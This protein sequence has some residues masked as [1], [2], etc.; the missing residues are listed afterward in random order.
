ME[1]EDFQ[2]GGFNDT[3]GT[4]GG[5][6]TGVLGALNKPKPARAATPAPNRQNEMLLKYGLIAGGVLLVIV[7]VLSL[8]RR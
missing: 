5:I 8:A 4:L 6:A 7:V 2:S 3:L 1:D